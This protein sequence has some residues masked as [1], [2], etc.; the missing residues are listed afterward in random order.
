MFTRRQIID[1]SVR[2]GCNK[3]LT[4]KGMVT[5]PYGSVFCIATL[6]GVYPDP[7]YYYN[8]QKSPN[9]IYYCGVYGKRALHR[10]DQWNYETKKNVA[11]TKTDGLTR[12]VYFFEKIGI[13]SK[14]YFFH[15]RYKY[16]DHKIKDSPNEIHDNEI[17]FHLE[18]VDR[19]NLEEV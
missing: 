11:V 18:F 13:Y 16:I 5:T 19:P 15:G 1:Y 10:L 9:D 17:L 7:I 12:F 3:D 8:N 14:Q 4:Q 6:S 2:M